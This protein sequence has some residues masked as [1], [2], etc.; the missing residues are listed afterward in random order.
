LRV[1]LQKQTTL[2]LESLGYASAQTILT[3]YSHSVLRCRWRPHH[4]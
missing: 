4:Q 3:V 2:T 1:N